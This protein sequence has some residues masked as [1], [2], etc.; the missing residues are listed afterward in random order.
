MDIDYYNLDYNN[1]DI[2]QKSHYKRYV[3]A[4][5]LIQKDDYVA[6]MAC[7]TG[8]GTMLISENC[9]K[10]EGF[11]IDEITINEI[12]KRYEKASNVSFYSNNLLDVKE[13]NKYDRIISFETI[14][15]FSPEEIKKLMKV[16][17]SCLKN[18]GK[19]IFSTPYD[20]EQ[21]IHSM[22]FH[23]TFKIKEEHIKKITNG[24][25]DIDFFMYQNYDNHELETHL[26]YKH[27][28]ICVAT[29]L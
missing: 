2:Y 18:E 29:K 19:L 20:Q 1:L 9:K 24:L 4:K 6:D 26:P 16:F 27:F 8:Y 11:D 12:K 7:G 23:R 5:S 25:F 28:I 17:H 21:C 13:Y 3:F 14:E 10:I 15:H 22:K